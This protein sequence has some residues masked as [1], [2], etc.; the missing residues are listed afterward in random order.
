MEKI[1]IK[2]Q[3]DY[4]LN[5]HIFCVENAKAVIQIIHGME[6]HQERYEQFISFLND[7]GYNVVSSDMRG[8]G[9]NAKILGYFK[10]KN[11]YK[12]LI[13]DQ[14]EITKFIKQKFSNLPIYI[15]AHSMG[16]IITRVL[17]Q[18]NSQDYSKVI[19]SGY[20]N[21]QNGAKIGIS[22]TNF[23][24]LFKGAK[25]KS[26]FIENMAIGAFN[27]QIKNARTNL[28][29][30][31]TN[32]KNVDDYIKDPLCGIGFT[33]SSYNDLFH[34]VVKMHKVNNYK[35]VNI[36]MPIL[37]LRGINDPCTG[38]NKGANDSRKILMDAGFKNISYIDYEGMRHEIL[39]ELDYKK[40]YNDI[41]NFLENNKKE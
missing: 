8:H 16:T 20:P 9:K 5:V 14:I 24:K 11:G 34:L 23:I 25:Y 15:F 38:G 22:I 40:V 7:N 28:D 2:S 27:K 6:E 17:L 35:E 19:L 3:D 32:E 33:V 41:L 18:T 4:E 12:F 1:I 36:N 39:N 13:S 30:L 10:D 31:S 29:W 37:M 26:K 21:Y